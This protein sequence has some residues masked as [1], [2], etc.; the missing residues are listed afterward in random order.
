MVLAFALVGAGLVLYS[1]AATLWW[2]PT[3]SKPLRLSWVLGDQ[4]NLSNAKDMG[5]T[6]MGGTSGQAEADVFDLDAN[7][8]TAATVSALHAKGKKV[9]CYFDAG[10]WESYRNDAGKFPGSDKTTMGRA[11]ADVKPYTGDPQYA[12]VNIIGKTDIGWNGSYWLDIRRTDILAPLMKARLQECKDK[13][14]DGVEPDEITNWGNGNGFGLTY[15]DQIAYNKAFAGWAHDMGLSVGLKGDLEQAHDL[16]PYFDWALIEECMQY[17]ECYKITNAPDPD[18]VTGLAGADGKD[19][20]G[21]Q[22]FTKNNKAVWVAEYKAISSAN[23]SA[24]ATNRVNA[25]QYKLGLPQ[26]GGFTA[27]PPFATVPDT[28]T[29]TNQA[30]TVTVASAVAT[31]VAPASFDVTAG[32]NDVDGKVTKIEIYRDGQIVKTCTLN[33]CIFQASAVAARSTPYVYTGRAYDDGN[34]SLSGESNPLSIL[35]TAAPAANKPPTASI[36]SSVTTAVAPATFDVT[37]IGSDP[38]GSITKLEVYQDGAVVKTCTSSPCAYR[39]SSLAAKQY[40]YAAKAYDNGSPVAN[41]NSNALNITVTSATTTTTGP[42]K[43]TGIGAITTA[44]W[45]G[46]QLTLNWTPSTSNNSPVGY[47]LKI[48]NAL[49]IKTSQNS[50]LMKVASGQ[51]LAVSVTAIDAAGASSSY[52][53]VTIAPTCV[54]FWCWLP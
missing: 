25:A 30:P 7:Y 18:Q 40:S 45:S 44:S 20:D 33:P 11:A 49:P 8:T 21:L 34:P 23:C 42:S 14:F 43:I 41:G 48:G 9:I 32:A 37:A 19:Y 4:I 28:S 6:N 38:D 52:G 36:T 54:M 29:S 24:A 5:T 12:N 51:K 35:I 27:C 3:S 13:G 15:Q 47:E 53:P 22:Y 16:W 1:Q 46:D 10:V 2:K 31:A 50:Y 26:G 39:A 17:N